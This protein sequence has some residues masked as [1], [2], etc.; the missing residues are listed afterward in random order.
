MSTTDNNA[1]PHSLAE[2]MRALRAKWGWIVAFGVFALIAGLIA[3]GSVVMA[4]A[5]AVFIV[6]FMMLMVGVAEIVAAFNAKDWGHRLSG[7][8]SA[9][10]MSSPA[11]SA[12]RTRS[13][14]RPS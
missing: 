1:G 10:S 2:G 5:S 4:T 13:R 14:R 11:S 7:C 8:C 6:G 3:L 9:R 12:C